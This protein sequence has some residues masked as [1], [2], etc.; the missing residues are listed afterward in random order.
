MRTEYE[1][2]AAQVPDL[3]IFMQPWY[4]DATCGGNQYWQVAV[5][6]EKDI[7]VGAWPYV[8]KKRWML[9][10]VI[11]PVFVRY[12]GPWVAESHRDQAQYGQVIKALEVQ[13]P[14]VARFS[15]DM[16]P[17]CTGLAP[18]LGQRAEAKE[19]ITYVLDGIDQEERLWQGV[20]SDYRKSKIP[21]AEQ[22]YT[23]DYEVPLDTFL[24]MHRATY[25]RQKMDLPA[26]DAYI[27]R[28]DAALAQR[29]ARAIIG[30]RH[31]ATG[32][33]HAASYLIADQKTCYLLMATDM[34]EHRKNAP[35]TLCLWESIKFAHD[36]WGVKRF[37]F[38]GSMVKQIAS[39]RKQ[40]GAQELVYQRI[41]WTK[42]WLKWVV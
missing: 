25:E 42:W 11:M 5:V 17:Q 40:F 8:L 39:V 30:A 26:T 20:Q 36:H 15:Q 14:D 7:V 34:A 27:R 37:D 29:N 19:R 31:R 32:E 10:T 22:H 24:S 18:L 2:F 3:P 38:L 35:N 41:E 6:M 28:L 9:Q 4:L 21:K 1:K 13:L 16:P 33:I 23:M 12:C